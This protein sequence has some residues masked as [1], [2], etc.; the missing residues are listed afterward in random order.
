MSSYPPPPP[1]GPQDP[2]GS[3]GP[4]GSPG[5]YGSGDP[6]PGQ[7][8][9]G[10]PY[11]GQYGQQYPGQYGAAPQGPGQYPGPGGQYP[12]GQYPGG[13]YPGYGPA[14][15]QY[16]GQYADQYPGQ[17]YGQYPGGAPA[18]ADDPLVPRSFSE[19]FSKIFAVVARSWQPLIVIQLVAALPGLVLGGLAE[20]LMTPDP[21]SYS[22]PGT[23]GLA[24]G[25]TVGVLV[26]VLISVVFALFAQGASV[27]VAV[28]DAVGR[29]AKAGEALSFAAGRALPLF[30]WGLLAGL[31]LVIG[32]LL[33]VLPGLYLAIVFGATLTGVVVIERQSI[34]RTF[35]LVNPRFW[36]T[37]GRLIIVGVI[38]FVYNLVITLLTAALAGA[39]TF[40]ATVLSAVLTLPISLLS[41]GVAVVTYAELRNRENPAVGS[42]ALAAQ[43]E[44]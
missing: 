10:Q 14:A 20:G 17:S 16:P 43:M 44:G 27:F 4:Y 30:G 11:P 31:M 36:P 33:L 32:F 7:Y 12:A 39:G 25:A 41:V 40:V 24:A 9:A 28:R 19:W 3:P 22:S 1:P 42:P 6:Y 34:G 13:Q 2:P 29:P 23:A 21:T 15:Q 26:A 8:G 18:G 38:A 5:Q 35:A 37:A